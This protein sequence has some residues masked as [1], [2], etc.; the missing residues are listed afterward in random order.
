VETHI[1]FV[2]VLILSNLLPIVQYFMISNC[3]CFFRIFRRKG[4]K[5][6]KK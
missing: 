5:T 6:L 1:Q 2:I 3:W 4:K